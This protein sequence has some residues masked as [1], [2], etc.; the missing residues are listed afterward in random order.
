VPEDAL[1]PVIDPRHEH[2]PV[3]RS[4]LDN[5]LAHIHHGTGVGD[6]EHSR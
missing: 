2:Q 4:V 5:D 1:E 3:R 6:D